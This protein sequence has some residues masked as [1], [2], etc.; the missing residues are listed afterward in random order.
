MTAAGSSGLPDGIFSNQKSQ[1]GYIL[2]CFAMEDVGTFYGN[3]VYFTAILYIVTS[4]IFP[5]WYVVPRK[6][7][8]P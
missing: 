1:F 3:L 6:I 7:W 4:Y 5:F 8:Q 2:E